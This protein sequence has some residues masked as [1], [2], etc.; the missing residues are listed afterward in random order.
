MKAFINTFSNKIKALYLLWFFLNF[1]IWVFTG[2][3]I[4]NVEYKNDSF[5]QSFLGDTSITH[6]HNNFFP[7]A[8]IK[9]YDISEFSFYVI[10]PILFLYL[11]WLYKKK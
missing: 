2:L 4:W 6:Y 1:F 11:K 10:T 7:F 8:N 3:H 9:N 5:L